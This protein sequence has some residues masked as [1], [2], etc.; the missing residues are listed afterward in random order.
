MNKKDRII[1]RYPYIK[2]ISRKDNFEAMMAIAAEINPDI[3]NFV[4]R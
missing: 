4:P 3:Y 1:N 2:H